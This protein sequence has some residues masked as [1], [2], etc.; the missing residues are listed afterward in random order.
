MDV[1]GISIGDELLLGQTINTNSAYI[2]QAVAQAG[3]QVVR[4]WTVSDRADE[5]RAA[6][7]GLHPST[8]LVLITG[9]LGPTKDDVTKKV[10]TEFFGGVLEYQ[11]VVYR[12][13][14]QLFGAMG[15]TPSE[16]NREQAMLPSNAEILFNRMGTAMGMAWQWEGRKVVSM[17]GVPY[18]MKHLM[19]EHVLPWLA[20]NSRQFVAHRTVRSQG[21]PES[22]LA[23]RLSLWEEA[24]PE[25]IKLAYL[26]SPGL[27]KLRL[28][29]RVSKE[30]ETAVQERLDQE[31]LALKA[32]LGK[33]YFGEGDVPLE[34]VLGDL[35]ASKGMSLATA[36]SCT[37]GALGAS[38]TSVP[39]SSRY[40]WGGIQAYQNT[41]K[42]KM[43]GVEEAA[44]AVH[45]AVSETVA[46]AMASG[47]RKRLGVDWAVSTTGIAGPDGGSHD[48]P[49]GT[50]WIAVAG[51]DGCRAE[52]YQMGKDRHR[53]VQK[54]VLAALNM[55][56][57]RV[58]GL[59]PGPS[60]GSRP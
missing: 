59:D 24:L 10:L 48:K 29:V 42:V 28:S 52:K 38:I 26:P 53:N 3:G 5:I 46:K 35:L 6:L 30:L 25:W 8:E 47:A 45:G 2:G 60:E 18:E 4:N 19:E 58:E 49:V 56:R 50:V 17:P 51:P 39:G 27:V 54:T 11:P 16:R 31:V 43:L 32:L 34:Q 20:G 13:I 33:A 9:G 41:V 1:E 21:I 7:N 23:D 37:G 15:R 57:V 55:L 22:D 14:E 12:H 36:E 44:L 40:Y